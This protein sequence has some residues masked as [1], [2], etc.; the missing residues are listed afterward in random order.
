MFSYKLEHVDME[1]L[2][3]VGICS[4]SR[5]R[6]LPSRRTAQAHIDQAPRSPAQR[7]ARQ[8]ILVMRRGRLIGFLDSRCAVG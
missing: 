7:S 8:T 2:K 5:F 6:A 3:L 1:I 4:G